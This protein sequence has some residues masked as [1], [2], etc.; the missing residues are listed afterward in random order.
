MSIAWVIGAAVIGLF[1]GLVSG[2]IIIGRIIIGSHPTREEITAA[3]DRAFLLGTLRRELTNYMVRRDPDRFV[4][5]FEKSLIA[6]EEIKKLGKSELRTQLTNFC[7]KHPMYTDFD[8]FGT[9]G[10]VLYEDAISWN[11]LEEIEEHYLDL[12]KFQNLQRALNDEWKSVGPA[13]NQD[14]LA[15]LKKYA[16]EIKDTKLKQRIVEAIGIFYRFRDD[17]ESDDGSLVLYEN[18]VFQIRNVHHFA[19]N[20]YGIYFKDTDEH[21]IYGFFIGDD[22]DEVY[23]GYYRSDE[24][25]EAEERLDEHIE[26]DGPFSAS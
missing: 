3:Q 1:V 26:F 20:R 6:T 5:L 11:S 7:E 15:H 18:D 24:K 16:Q 17:Y 9:R 22:I 21:V 23:Y 19:E 14:D 4:A 10:H 13:N 12:V 8:L 2:A 25:Y